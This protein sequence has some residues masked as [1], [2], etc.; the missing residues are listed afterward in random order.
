MDRGYKVPTGGIGRILEIHVD[1]HGVIHTGV[2]R[3]IEGCGL[4]E[5]ISGGCEHVGH[6]PVV[7][8]SHVLTEGY[9]SVILVDVVLHRIHGSGI[10]GSHR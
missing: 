1:R 5:L 7:A 2:L 3:N 4:Q 9:P 6:R 8:Q 10:E